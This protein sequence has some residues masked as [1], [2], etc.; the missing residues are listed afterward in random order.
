MRNVSVMAAQAEQD[1]TD[2]R[3]AAGDAA[4]QSFRVF[5]IV[6]KRDGL[7]V[8]WAGVLAPQSIASSVG[9]SAVTGSERA[10]MRSMAAC[11]TAALVI[12]CSQYVDCDEEFC[13]IISP[14]IA[15]MKST[16]NI[17]F[18]MTS[19]TSNIFCSF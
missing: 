13:A 10:A 9:Y 18:F 17:T 4:G 16:S 5:A 1:P 3:A 19:K 7:A 2:F 14:V 15:R 8:Q 11:A 6:A 12:M